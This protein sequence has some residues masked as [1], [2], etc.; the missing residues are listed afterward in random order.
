MGFTRFCRCFLCASLAIRE[1]RAKLQVGCVS[2]S[3]VRLA[4][5]ELAHGDTMRYG[6]GNGNGIGCTPVA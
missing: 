2:R 3:P 6:N 4:L 1:V 5:R